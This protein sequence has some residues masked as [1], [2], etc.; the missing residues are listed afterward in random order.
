[1]NAFTYLCSRVYANDGKD[2]RQN[3]LLCA[4]LLTLMAAQVSAQVQVLPAQRLSRWGITA[5]NYSGITPLGDGRYAVVSDKERMDGFY[6]WEIS[7]D[8]VSGDVTSVHPIEFR[9]E[10]PVTTDGQGQSRKD[11]EGVVYVPLRGTLFISGEGNQEICEYTLD[12]MATGQS[13]NVPEALKQTYNN[14]G[15]EALAYDTLRHIFYTTTENCLTSY[16]KP[17]P[18]GSE[19]TTLLRIQ[20]FDDKL[21]PTYQWAYLLDAPQCGVKGRSHAHG[22]VAI[23]ALPDG[24]LAVLER[25]V[26]ITQDYNKSRVWN[27]LYLTCPDDTPS[28]SSSTL[29]SEARPLAMPKTL[30]TEWSTRFT[31]LGDT[32]ANFEGMC[33]GQPTSDG[34]Q[35]LILVSD[36]QGGMGIGPFRLKDWIRVIVLPLF[37]P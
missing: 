30:L 25:E 11:F 5:A 6:L 28:L 37:E 32:W 34:R 33:L 18:V 9:G 3:V 23:T 7:Q 21:Q 36:S 22:V 24:S 16:G 1:M 13:L 29:A 35:T 26:H 12:G 8:S 17:A 10:S 27:K 31:L 15:F 19:T 20:A 14:Y 2:M 4:L